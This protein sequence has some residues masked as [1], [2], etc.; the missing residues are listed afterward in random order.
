MKRESQ[1]LSD[2]LMVFREDFQGPEPDVP[3]T[4]DS[5]IDGFH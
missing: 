4:D 5:N 2:Q 1:L 3:E